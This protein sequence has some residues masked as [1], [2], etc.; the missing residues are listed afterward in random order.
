[1]WGFFYKA[2]HPHATL[3]A[4]LRLEYLGFDPQMWLVV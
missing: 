1:M 3:P 2:W 4:K